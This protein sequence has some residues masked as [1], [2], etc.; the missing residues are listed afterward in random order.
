MARAMK[1]RTRVVGALL[2]GVV[3]TAI[4]AAPAS[5]QKRASGSGGSKAL[6]GTFT[7][8]S[9][10]PADSGTVPTGSYFRMVQPGGSVAAGP[11][12]P[13][14]DSLASDKT[15]S[16]LSAGTRGL[17]TGKY[18]PQPTPAFDSAGNGVAATILAP[19]KFF[20]VGFAVSTNPTD[21][22]TDA[23][24][25]TPRITV[26]RKGKLGGNL[27]AFGVAYSNQ[28]FNQGSPKPDGSKPTGT[29]GPTGTFDAK[30]GEFTLDWS[31]AI[32]G[33]PF[34]RFT[35]VWHLEGT[36]EKAAKQ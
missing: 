3:A 32:L 2:C 1:F 18:Q 33:G 29:A 23:A 31:S 7:V 16:L 15:Y 20:G 17:T 8:T 13:N 34:D 24:T 35:G 21:P 30:T 36:F 6:V 27:S 14:A 10:T 28:Y 26:N 11:F 22:Q 4:V 5:A 9:G 19:T 25:K 12:V